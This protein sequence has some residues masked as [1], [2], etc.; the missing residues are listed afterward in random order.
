MPLIV[1]AR[2]YYKKYI[3]C[4]GFVKTIHKTYAHNSCLYSLNLPP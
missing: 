3:T 4:F 1:L 2:N